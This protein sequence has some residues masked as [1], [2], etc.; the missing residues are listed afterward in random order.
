[1]LQYKSQYFY[2]TVRRPTLTPSC[3]PLWEESDKGG[4]GIIIIIIIT[5]YSILQEN[6]TNLTSD[7]VKRTYAN[8]YIYVQ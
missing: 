5:R 2:F 1:M 3:T 8:V 7:V 4:E 6:I